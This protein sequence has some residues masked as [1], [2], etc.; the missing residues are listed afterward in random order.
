MSL[1]SALAAPF[2]GSTALGLAGSATDLWK[3]GRESDEAQFSRDWQERL[4]N[5]AY[6]R[7]V[8]DMR[9]AGLNPALAYQQGGASTPSGSTASVGDLRDPVSSGLSL[10]NLVATNELL[11]QQAS[12]ARELARKTK[13]EADIV[14]KGVPKADIVEDIWST[15]RDA[16]RAGKHVVQTY[17]LIPNEKPYRQPLVPLTERQRDQLRNKGFYTRPARQR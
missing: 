2:V 4:S 8:S 15:A 16:Y 12:S 11:R 13:Y 17:P 1:F 9:A 10:K 14:K 3:V 5:T 6:Q 7:A